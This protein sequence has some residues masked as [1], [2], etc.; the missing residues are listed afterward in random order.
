VLTSLATIYNTINGLI[1][2]WN[3]KN[4]TTTQKVMATV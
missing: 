2:T 4:K 1:D 3:D